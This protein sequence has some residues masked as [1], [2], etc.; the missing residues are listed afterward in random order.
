MAA[1]STTDQKLHFLV[2]V[3]HPHD[4][5]HCAGTCGIHVQR[6]DSVTVVCVSDGANTHNERLHDELLKP[7]EQR[8]PAIIDQT[9]EDYARIKEDEFRKVCAL[10]GVT[11]VRIFPFPDHPF[12]ADQHPG[13][14][15][16][17][18]DVILE[19]RPDV[20]IAHRPYLAGPNAFV[21]AQH[22]DH[23]ESTLAALEGA[24][25][26]ARPNIKTKQQPHTIAAT[27]YMGVYFMPN[28]IDFY[29]DI[30]DWY[31]QRVEAEILFASQSHTSAFARKR[32]EIGAGT[33]GWCCGV[34]Y[35]EGYVRS[36]ADLL[37]RIIV[38]EIALQRAAEPRV[39]RM[40]R[41]AGES[42]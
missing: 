31:D 4:F 5:T 42:K 8:D 23:V 11:D 7:A 18:R 28:E 29:V 12:I 24:S 34:G 30:T 25:L 21:S 20:L 22:N 9:F 36:R 6:G 39:N 26:A 35:A 1:S 15:E 37:P 14:V 13:A 32:A 41:I 3:A 16:K 2:V 40:N 27:Y 17:I 19:I 10:F 33:M 38:P